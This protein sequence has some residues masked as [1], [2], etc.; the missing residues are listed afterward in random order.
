MY[1]VSMYH[2]G[3]LVHFN[4]HADELWKI[5]VHFLIVE[6]E[7]FIDN[8]AKHLQKPLTW[9]KVQLN[10]NYTLTPGSLLL[11]K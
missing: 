8:V 9:T 3:H 10:K 6:R 5:K 4:V 7:Q 11:N 1:K 2:F